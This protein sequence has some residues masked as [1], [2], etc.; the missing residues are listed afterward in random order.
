MVISM[1]IRPSLRLRSLVRS[2]FS[3]PMAQ[4]G[5]YFTH[6]VPFGKMCAVAMNR[7]YKSKAKVVAELYIKSLS[8]A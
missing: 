4:S 6:R 3:L 7:V 2:I 8:G 1:Y 5:S